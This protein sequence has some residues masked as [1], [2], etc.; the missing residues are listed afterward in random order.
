MELIASFIC[1][2]ALVIAWMVL[3]STAKT[4]TMHGTMDAVPS[5]A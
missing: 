2:F 4:T 3:P 5:A 1:F